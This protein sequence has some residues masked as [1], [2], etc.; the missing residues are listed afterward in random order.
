[1]YMCGGWCRFARMQSS[2][3]LPSDAQLKSNVEVL[4]NAL[5]TTLQLQGR[6]FEWNEVR[7]RHCA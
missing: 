7:L 6:S 5:H 4:S 2:T 3:T 1:M